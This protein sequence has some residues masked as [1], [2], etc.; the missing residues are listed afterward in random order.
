MLHLGIG[1]GVLGALE[2]RAWFL[3]QLLITAELIT[4]RLKA[5]PSALVLFL[6]TALRSYDYFHYTDRETEARG[7]SYLVGRFKV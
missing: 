6:A 1:R 3:P 5:K 7:G 2:R 4:W